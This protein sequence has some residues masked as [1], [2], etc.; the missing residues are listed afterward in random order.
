MLEYRTPVNRH[1]C[2]IHRDVQI[3]NNRCS[4][5]VRMRTNN[6]SNYVRRRNSNMGRNQQQEIVP[7][8]NPISRPRNNPQR[9]NRLR[10]INDMEQYQD[11]LIEGNRINLNNFDDLLNLE[12]VNVGLSIKSL[13]DNSKVLFN[14]YNNKCTICLESMEKKII[15]RFKCN[16]EFHIACCD[17]WFEDKNSCP[18]C[19]R[20]FN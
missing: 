20:K 3:V 18:N 11:L 12:D 8:P 17:K 9:E 1:F 10:H 2:S 16:H 19:R 14:K 7:P 5:C 13:N 6:Y 4:V 15:R